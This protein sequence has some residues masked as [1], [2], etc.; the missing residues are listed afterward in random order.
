[1]EAE[2]LLEDS[3]AYAAAINATVPDDTLQWCLQDSASV[4]EASSSASI[5]DT[6]P[7][8]W[9]AQGPRG[10]CMTCH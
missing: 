10:S 7:G 9:I 2:S 4:R 1:M 8:F 5:S 6:S 3:Y